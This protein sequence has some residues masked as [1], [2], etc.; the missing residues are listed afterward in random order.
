MVSSLLLR[1]SRIVTSAVLYYIHTARHPNPSPAL[2]HQ[3]S[4]PPRH[5]QYEISGLRY[6]TYIRLC[7][8]QKIIFLLLA[9]D[10][11]FY[12]KKIDSW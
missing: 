1:W 7:H 9:T 2:L 8:L 11:L 5:D 10:I 3:P 12:L 6:K 4:R